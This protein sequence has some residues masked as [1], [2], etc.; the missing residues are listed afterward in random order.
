[1]TS[2]SRLFQVLSP[3]FATA[4]LSGSPPPFHA[5][6]FT[7]S[8]IS[9]VLSFSFTAPPDLVRVVVVRRSVFCTRVSNCNVANFLVARGYLEFN[10]F[11]FC[12]H[13]T[14]AQALAMVNGLKEEEPCSY[15]GPPTISVQAPR[16]TP[17]SR[18]ADSPLSAPAMAH[19]LGL[20]S[21][22]W[23]RSQKIASLLP[24]LCSLPQTPPNF[25]S[26][27]NIKYRK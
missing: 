7:S 20:D 25:P 22:A 14:E 6:R 11:R 24:M 4:H 17:V 5:S 18:G 3:P 2:T 15:A 1:M 10:K 27:R 26:H 12:L 8:Y 21:A 23:G 16:Q 19:C 9:S 13:S